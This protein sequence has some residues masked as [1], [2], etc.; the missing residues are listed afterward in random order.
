MTSAPPF[1][2]ETS[3]TEDERE[4][5]DA[6][7]VINAVERLSEGELISLPSAGAPAILVLPRGK[8]VASLK[9][10]ADEWRNVPERI[11][12][13]AKL[14]TLESF[15][16]HVHRF[17][18]PSTAVFAN[19][20]ELIAVYDYH[21][22]AAESRA[23]AA[24][25]CQ[26]RARYAFPYS[27]EWCAWHAVHGRELQQK[28][29]AEFIEEHVQD[30]S[31]PKDTDAD[32]WFGELGFTLASPSTMLGLSRGLAVRV[33]SEAVSR[34][35]L[36]TGEMEVSYKEQ[37]ADS[38]GQP[39]KVPGGFMLQIP[40]FENGP[41]YRIPA[42]L[43]YRVSGG[44]VLWTVMLYRSDAVRR[45][46]IQDAARNVADKTQTPVFRGYPEAADDD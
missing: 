40:P 4:L 2:V 26:H 11:I 3:T 35:N 25:N 9:A 38:T 23:P 5:N 24:D 6:A 30:I 46:A 33:E 18:R 27:K 12:G 39:L 14:T 19:D 43:R 21:E 20:D 41:L 22:G 31:A 44:K 17:K 7:A 29:F 37:H 16:E 32:R 10:L 45:D 42:R 8:R 1:K 36:S 15:I 28:P 34:P 13:T